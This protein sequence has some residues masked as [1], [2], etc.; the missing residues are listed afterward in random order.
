[1]VPRPLVNSIQGSKEARRAIAKG[2]VP[3]EWLEIEPGDREAAAQVAPVVSLEQDPS[4]GDPGFAS[5][6]AARREE[7]EELYAA[8]RLDPAAKELSPLLAAVLLRGVGLRPD[9][10]FVD[11]GSSRGGLVFSAASRCRHAA[12]LE[13]SRRMHAAA[14]R[15]VPGFLASFPDASVLFDRGDVRDFDVSP[16]DIVFCAIRGALSRPRVLKPVLDTL[17]NASGRR[18]RLLCAGFGLDG[19]Q[20]NKVYCIRKDSCFDNVDCAEPLYGDDNGPR[21]ILEYVFRRD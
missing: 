19:L 18:R 2:S 3:V 15:A 8:G 5:H 21:V 4:H 10:T 1:M 17:K 14:L 9:D 11:L 12:G 20:V 13:L 16:F 7:F 6:N